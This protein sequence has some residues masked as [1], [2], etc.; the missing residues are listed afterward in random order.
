MKKNKKNSSSNKRKIKM[1]KNQ[2]KIINRII[3][4]SKNKN[5][6]KML[7]KIILFTSESSSKNYKNLKYS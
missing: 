1:K 6:Q 2:N 4:I 3:K 5:F 7:I